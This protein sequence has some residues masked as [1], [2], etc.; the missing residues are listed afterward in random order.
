MA[1][2]RTALGRKIAPR[3]KQIVTNK[4]ERITVELIRTRLRHGAYL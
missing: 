3:I 1:L 2:Q 4:F